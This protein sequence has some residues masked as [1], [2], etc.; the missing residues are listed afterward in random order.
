VDGIM[1]QI[2][3]GMYELG[4]KIGA[5]GGG[6][7]YLGKHLRLGK[8]VVLKAD[9]RTLSTKPETLRR[10]VNAMKDL[11]HQYI[12]QL[13]DY[14]VENGAVYTVMDYIEGESLDK[15]LK[16]GERLS[17]PQVIEWACELLEALCY[18][19]S[20]PPYGILHGDI[21]PANIMLTPQGDIRLI[22]FNIALALKEEGAVRVGYSRGYASPE[23]YGVKYTSPKGYESG[24]TRRTTSRFS[25]RSNRLGETIQVSTEASG[26]GS[27]TEKRTILLDARSD[28]YSLGATLYHLLS[29]T[30]PAQ[31]AIE[32]QP[33][34]PQEFSPV[35]IEIIQ[36]AMEPDP[37]Q[38]YQKAEEMLYDFEH[39]REKDPRT[40]RHRR[41]IWTAAVCLSLL[42]LAGGA[43]AFAGLRQ[44]E[45]KQA[46]AALS[47][48]QAEEEARQAEEAERQAKEQEARENAALSAVRSAENAYST[49]DIT[50]A[51]TFALQALEVESPYAPQAQKVLTDIL[52]VYDLSAGLKPWLTV[53]L[54]SQPLKLTISQEGTRLAALYAYRVLVADTTT[55]ATVA[56]LPTQPTSASGIQFLNED[57]LIY[58]GEDGLTAYDLADGQALWKGRP[59][60]RF[61]ISGDGTR[62]AGVYED[63]SQS[64]IYDAATGAEI[65]TISFGTKHQSIPAG[66]G[67]L[68]DQ[69][70]EFLA[71]NED[72]SLMAVS[73][74]DGGLSLYDL[75]DGEELEVWDTSEYTHF[76]GGFSKEWF[77]VSTWNTEDCF[78][79]AYDMTTMTQ[80]GTLSAHT[81]FRTRCD[82]QGIYIASENLLVELDPATGEERELAYTTTDIVSFVRSTDGHV[83]ASTK[84]H[85]Y[86]YFDEY[87]QLITQDVREEGCEML[88]TATPYAVVASM[89]S[90]VIQ[91][92]KLEDRAEERLLFYDPSIAHVEARL[93][94]DRSTVMLFQYNQFDLF[95]LDG[96]LIAHTEIPDASEVY[97]QQYRREGTESWL[98]VTYHEGFKRAY[99]A[100]DGSILWERQD[101]PPDGSLQ[102]TFETSRW[103]IKSPLH[104]APIVYDRQTGEKYREL[105][106][107]SLLTYVTE[108][109]EYLV[110]QYISAQGERYALLLNQDCETLAYLPGLC[111][112]VGETL[113]FDD[114]MGNLRQSRLYSAQEL[115]ALVQTNSEEV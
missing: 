93:S 86:A 58:A 103:R 81:P 9:Q 27:Y 48:R 85:T 113:I 26:M 67:V 61:T 95:L 5:G 21:K 109:G 63:E 2:V 33:L 24:T 8:L 6:V 102:E 17:Q 55:G 16:R 89:E 40:K 38:R 69:E 14:V 13:Y 43:S 45:R 75:A 1:S 31:N 50:A 90:P 71:L 49:G 82:E 35:L 42:F 47:A 72:A 37:D 44:M 70:N 39:L 94:A 41:Q 114:D 115:K 108:V 62:I 34:S 77:A 29:G 7:V 104:G 51:K 111:D 59:T 107:N 78:F 11:T 83:L 3:A 76:E 25:R 56:D 97:D 23:H 28:I 112:I 54:P 52:G 64:I 74:E 106:Q 99:S 105:E 84:D 22:D 92:F 66:G 30:R 98:E 46:A 100:E 73:F 53:E 32:V 91:I 101:E 57:T 80:S 19:H 88:A 20:R 4:E 96:T 10:E 79:Q 110:T 12:P 87:A 68:A 18:L 15:P 60:T 36:K 65:Q